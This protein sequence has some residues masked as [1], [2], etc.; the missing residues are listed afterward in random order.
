MYGIGGEKKLTERELDWLPGYANSR[1][2]GSATPRTRRSQHDVWGALLD[3]VYLHFKA[4]DHLDSRIW[5]ILDAQVTEALK[6]WREPD[7][8]IWEVRGELQHFTSSKIM[9][10]VAVDRGAKIARMTGE[11]GKAAEWELA[12]QEIKDDILA[13]GVDERGVLTQHYGTKA[14]DASAAAGA[15]GALPAGGRPDHPEHRAGDRRR[16]DGQRA[17]AALQGG[18]DRRRLHRRGG[19]LHHLLVLAGVGAV[20]DRRVRP[21]PQAVRP[22]AVL[23]RPARPLRR[24]DRRPLRPA[25]GQLPAG[26]HPPGADQR[27]AA[28]DQARGRAP[29]RSP[30]APGPVRWTPP[31]DATTCPPGEDAPGGRAD[32]SRARSRPAPTAR[33]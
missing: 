5:G 6:H 28:R 30:R 33:G 24:G 26:V 8:G 19:Q 29:A 10:W 7:A 12:A 23:R 25:P 13:N 32:R 1:P 2:S 22:A 11:D 18:G 3:S 20:R 4:A 21:G 31:S 17:G 16:A 9:C 27:G 15:A 14:L